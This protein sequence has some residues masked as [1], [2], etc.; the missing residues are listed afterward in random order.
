MKSLSDNDI[1]AGLQKS[2]HYAF[3]E[4]HARF[5]YPLYRL[6]FKK[7]GD[8]DETGDLLQDMFVEI[9]EKR[10]T[11]YIPN[12]LGNWLRNR[13]WYKIAMYFR[14]R[15]FKQQHQENFRI[16][17]EK[18]K[19]GPSVAIDG[20]EFKES[21]LY[22]EELLDII[23]QCI[24][25]MPDRMK[26]IFRLYRQEGMPIKEIAESLELSPKTVKVQLHRGLLK[27]KKATEN[28]K[29]NMNELLLLLWLINHGI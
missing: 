25:N 20:L 14:Q 28:Q 23:Q 26:E 8:K 29:V 11:L 6:A 24:E 3:Q 2:E 16:F 22:Y 15:G 4:L 18:E 19:I 17:L 21:N 27:L 10:E 9:W 7:L 1:I 12:E 13:L 5:W